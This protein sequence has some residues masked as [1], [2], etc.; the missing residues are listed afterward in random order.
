MNPQDG[1]LTAQ[2]DVGN[3]I[4]SYRAHGLG[5]MV[6]FQH[7]AGRGRTKNGG[8]S[9]AETFHWRDLLVP[10]ACADVLAFGVFPGD[11]DLGFDDVAV[12]THDDLLQFVDT[13]DVSEDDMVERTSRTRL[14]ASIDSKK[15]HKSGLDQ[16]LPLI[17]PCMVLPGCQTTKVR[18]PIVWC[19][20]G[21][22]DVMKGYLVFRDITDAWRKAEST[23]QS[24]KDTLQWIS[25]RWHGLTSRCGRPFVVAVFRDQVPAPKLSTETSRAHKECTEELKTRIE[26][27]LYLLDV[28]IRDHLHHDHVPF[29]NQQ[30]AES[31]KRRPMQ[32]M[33]DLHLF[34]A[35]ALRERAE[36]VPREK[37][38]TPDIKFAN[39]PVLCQSKSAR[40]RY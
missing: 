25:D 29:K 9:G 10:M 31:E 15:M 14:Q 18:Q 27:M 22:L 37:M 4:T 34:R 36:K 33:L 24:R 28:A 8:E 30:K 19:R 3:D 12:S 17:A 21:M 20:G 1:D 11:P 7:D 6:S 5:I 2:D 38:Y 16:L 23:S 13:L 39:A 26:K 35:L 32:T 40:W